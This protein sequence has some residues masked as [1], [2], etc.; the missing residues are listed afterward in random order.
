MY[1]LHWVSLYLVSAQC[2]NVVSF[3]S[4]SIKWKSFLGLSG[5]RVCIL[6]RRDGSIC[7]YQL[8]WRFLLGRFLK[9][10]IMVKARVWVAVRIWVLVWVRIEIRASLAVSIS[11]R[12]KGKGSCGLNRDLLY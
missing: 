10:G 12:V 5:N 9:N 4:S 1:P 3:L 6:V 7:N 11:I 8:E 2:L